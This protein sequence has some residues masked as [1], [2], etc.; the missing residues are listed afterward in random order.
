MSRFLPAHLFCRLAQALA[1]L[2]ALTLPGAAQLY[3]FTELGTLNGV[4]SYPTA[5]NAHGH[6]SG[7]IFLP[8][9]SSH[10]FF[11][12]KDDGMLDL[13][14]LGGTS[15]TAIDL[16]NNGQVVGW[17]YTPVSTRAFLWT[18]TGGMQDVGTLFPG[19][20]VAE[21]VNSS[22]QVA[23][24]SW[25]NDFS[26]SHAFVWSSGSGMVDIGTLGGANSKILGMND[27]GQAVG[28]SSTAGGIQHA[29]VWSLATG[30]VDIGTLGVDSRANAI[31]NAGH[32]VGF[33]N[34]DPGSHPQAFLWTQ[35]GGIQNLGTLGGSYSGADYINASGHVVGFAYLPGD[36]TV[37]S[38]LWTPG[39]GMQD[40]GRQKNLPDDMTFPYGLNDKDQVLSLNS[41]QKMFLWTAKTGL[42]PSGAKP[43]IRGPHLINNAGQFTCEIAHSNSAILATPI[44]TVMLKSTRNP[45]PAGTPVKFK[46]KISSVAGP[47]PDGEEVQFADGATV[48]GTGT[49]HTGSATFSTAALAPGTHSITAIYV[50]DENY[51]SRTSNVLSQVVNP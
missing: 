51:P 12:T 10:A 4:A 26:A 22:G 43:G 38:F 15:S 2:M 28:F 8:D 37:H 40:V 41:R 49:L 11:W 23:G 14:T 6:V 34:L 7:Y 44:M 16:N 48:I 13:G 29:F 25:K 45:A 9:T 33:Y 20:S 17:A 27:L 1:L 24:F 19:G 3:D 18:K 30:I 35:A 46:A 42:K 47:P 32:V 5:V 50:G 31:D 39:G 21:L 36:A